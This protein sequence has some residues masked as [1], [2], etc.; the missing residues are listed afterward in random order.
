[1]ENT[2]IVKMAWTLAGEYRNGS[3][4]GILV[5]IELAKK[6]GWDTDEKS[7][8]RTTIYE[9]LKE[10][11]ETV[12]TEGKGSEAGEYGYCEIEGTDC[13][14]WS[15]NACFEWSSDRPSFWEEM[16]EKQGI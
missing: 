15:T 12:Y 2:A 3:N 11:T 16:L 7:A 14:W 6:F 1:M 13:Y 8:I 10:M 5:D 9:G 4:I